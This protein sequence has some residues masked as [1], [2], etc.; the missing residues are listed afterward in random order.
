MKAKSLPPD[1]WIQFHGPYSPHPVHKDILSQWRFFSSVLM[2]SPAHNLFIPH[3]SFL[4]LVNYF[5]TK[6]CMGFTLQDCMWILYSCEAYMLQEETVCM[7]ITDDWALTS[8]RIFLYI[9][10]KLFP[11][12]L[13][14]IF[15]RQHLPILKLI[16]SITR[17]SMIKVIIQNVTLGNLTISVIPEIPLNFNLCIYV[18]AALN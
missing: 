4:K 11:Q 18:G 8:F 2:S 6:K 14:W 7:L 12:V 10:R 9:A 16:L 17:K 3:N 15:G 1:F 13:P 5:Y